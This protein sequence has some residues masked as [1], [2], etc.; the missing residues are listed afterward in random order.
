ME[1]ARALR[2]KQTQLYDLRHAKAWDDIDEKIR[3]DEE[4][5]AHIRSEITTTSGEE[6]LPI[7]LALAPDREDAMSSSTAIRPSDVQLQ[8]ETGIYQILTELEIA[9]IDN[10]GMSCSK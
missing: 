9:N 8:A 2:E 3:S 5:I 7:V 1:T 4:N 10:K 6:G